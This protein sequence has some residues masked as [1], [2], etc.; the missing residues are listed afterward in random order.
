MWSLSVLSFSER[1]RV[2]YKNKSRIGE[3]RYQT[4]TVKCFRHFSSQIARNTFSILPLIYVCLP[5]DILFCYSCLFISMANPG[6]GIHQ[7]KRVRRWLGLLLGEQ[8]SGP[9]QKKRKSGSQNVFDSKMSKHTPFGSFI[10]PFL[11][12]AQFHNIYDKIIS[13][14]T[15]NYN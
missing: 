1:W 5:F 11:F 14:W 2:V 9:N 4:I 10:L 15:D 8:T 12:V 3:R 6:H 7:R 13:V